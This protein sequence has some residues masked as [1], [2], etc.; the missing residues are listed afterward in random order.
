[1]GGLF[2]SPSPPPPAKQTPVPSP[3]DPSSIDARRRAAKAAGLAMGASS[4][5]LSENLGTLGD[6]AGSLAPPKRLLG[7]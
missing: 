2:G 4:T 6:A 1:M 3:A 5:L 7:E